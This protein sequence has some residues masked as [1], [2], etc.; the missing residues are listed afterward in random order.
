[1]TNKPPRP[2][3]PPPTP[4]PDVRRRRLL[5]RGGA[6]AGGLTAFAAGYGDVVAKGAK[7]LISGSSGVGTKSATRGNSLTPEFRIDPATGQLATQ[8]GQVVSPSSC[9]GCWTQCGVRVRVDTERGQIIRIAGNPYHPLST[10]NAVPMALPVR[11]AYA[12]L[13]GDSGIEGRAT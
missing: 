7:G 13:G 4:A 10:T 5:L 11:Q 9:L 3:P 1:M 12:M 2:A 8:P 6:V